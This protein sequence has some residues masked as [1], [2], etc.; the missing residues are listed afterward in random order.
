MPGAPSF[1]RLS[2]ER[3]GDQ[4][5]PRTGLGAPVPDSETRE[6]AVLPKIAK[7]KRARRATPAEEDLAS[8]RAK[9]KRPAQGD[10]TLPKSSVRKKKTGLV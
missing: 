5:V 7:P 4:P 2:A 8:T 3:V 9:A 6:S 1:P 10:A